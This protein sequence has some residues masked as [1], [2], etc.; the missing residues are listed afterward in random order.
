MD[1]GNELAE[2]L[3]KLH[4]DGRLSAKD[5]CC[6]SYWAAKAG[7]KGPVKTLGHN[8]GAPT[9]HFQ[10]HLDRVAGLRGSFE[11]FVTLNVP[12]HTRASGDRTVQGVRVVP[13]HECLNREV[14]QDPAI[15]GRVRPAEWPPSF[16][17][18]P[19]VRAAPPGKVVPLAFYMDAAQYTKGGA[20]VIVFVVSNLVTGARH[21]VAVLKKKDLCRCGCRGW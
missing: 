16:H 6:L 19:V 5:T 2:L 11:D 13:P 8:P 18:H 21:L 20:A 12:G 3:L 14:V 15:L 1:A 4:V 7:A 10:R 9:G 17:D